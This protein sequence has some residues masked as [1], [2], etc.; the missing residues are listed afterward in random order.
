MT[1]SVPQAGNPVQQKKTP[2]Q[3][4]SQGESLPGIPEHSTFVQRREWLLE[5]MVLAFRVF[6]RLGY[7]DG[8]A[9]HISVRDPED[10]HS[11]WTVSNRFNGHIE[12]ED[13]LRIAHT[14]QNPL[15]VH[16]G[17]LKTSDMI[18]V[19]YEGMAVGGTTP[20]YPRL[21]FDD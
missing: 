19:N 6:A 1:S 12:K 18:L 20:E 3:L 8:M 15:A 7:T 21:S 2:L 4:I 16:F 10:P 17:L 9:G 14:L 11:F 5:R 13:I